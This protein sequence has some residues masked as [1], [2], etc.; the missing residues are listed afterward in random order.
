MVSEI[1]QRERKRQIL[2]DYNYMHY[3]KNQKMNKVNK[4]GLIH[5]MIDKMVAR[6]E[7]GGDRWNRWREQESQ[8][9]S[10]KRNQLGSIDN[11]MLTTLYGNRWQL[12]LL[13][14]SICNVCK[15][16]ITT[17]YPWNQCNGLYIWYMYIPFLSKQVDN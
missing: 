2:Y 9:S 14:W 16:Q 6:G 8:P 12:D 15:C 13:Q 1:N 7:E 5:T 4:T 3:L 17:L 10:H 11:S